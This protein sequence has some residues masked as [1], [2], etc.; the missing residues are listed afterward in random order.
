MKRIPRA[1][2]QRIPTQGRSVEM[3]HAILD[4]AV[5]VL[6]EEGTVGFTTNRVA[7][8]AGISPGSLYQYFGNKEMIVAGVVERGL[9]DSETMMRELLGGEALHQAIEVTLEGL[10]RALTAHL[11]P[12]RDLM[13]EILYV[14]PMSPEVGMMRVLDSRISDLIR[15]WFTVQAGRYRVE[16]PAATIYVVTSTLVFGFLRWLTDPW[17]TYDTDR[18]VGAMVRTVASQV[19]EISDRSDG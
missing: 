4:A 18:F 16:D 3:V 2:L 8:V 6:T 5:R 15:D 19:R 12:Y 14:T 13:R 17:Q 7:E 1:S 11:T 9:I 10:L